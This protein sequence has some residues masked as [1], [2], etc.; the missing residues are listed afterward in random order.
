MPRRTPHLA[1]LW[2]N[3]NRR[4]KRTLEERVSWG[5]IDM[6]ATQAGWTVSEGIAA[7][8]A[9]EATA[10]AQAAHEAVDRYK[11]VTGIDMSDI[12]AALPS[13]TPFPEFTQ[14]KAR[15]RRQDILDYIEVEPLVMRV[16]GVLPGGSLY[17]L[18]AQRGSGKTGWCI[19]LALALAF[20]RGDLIGIEIEP[21]RVLYMTAENPDMLKRRLRLSLIK[22]GIPA[23]IRKDAC[24]PLAGP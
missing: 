2:E 16:D 24:A 22:F 8:E 15:P 4:T 21:C 19:N 17:T 7:R 11:K 20:D 23:T 1:L 10:K 3:L 12:E 14:T 5:T 6:L 9:A 18:T 13:F